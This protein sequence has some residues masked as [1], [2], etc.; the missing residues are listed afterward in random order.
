MRTQEKVPLILNI[1]NCNSSLEV[2]LPIT[3]HEKAGI[4]SSSQATPGVRSFHEKA[5]NS[6]LFFT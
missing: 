3:F 6:F 1:G 4:L 2:K 5:G